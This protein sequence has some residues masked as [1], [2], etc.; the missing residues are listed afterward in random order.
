MPQ[1]NRGFGWVAALYEEIIVTCHGPVMGSKD[2]M[3][4]FRREVTGMAAATFFFSRV[5]KELNSKP[6]VC[7]WSDNTSLVGRLRRLI[8]SNPIAG[9]LMNDHDMHSIIQKS[10]GNLSVL[11]VNHVKGHQDRE[12]RSLTT[13]EKVSVEANKLAMMPVS[14]VRI[15][16][17]DWCEECAPMLIIRGKTITKREGISL[18]MSAEKTELEKWQSEKLKMTKHAE[19]RAMKNL[20]INVHSFA[21]K[22]VYH[23][24]PSGKR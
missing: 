10:L 21:I 15:R 1:K 20:P 16:E 8:D 23:W 7:L 13:T 11:D 5:A 22:C 18:C 14:E 24:L 9:F 17:P 6:E 12:Q 4:S 2:Q 19:H 3:S